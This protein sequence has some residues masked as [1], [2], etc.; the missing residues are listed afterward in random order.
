M[1]VV[2][3]GAG[4]PLGVRVCRLQHLEEVEAR[5]LDVLLHLRLG[6]VVCDDVGLVDDLVR[7]EL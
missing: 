7:D 2:V 4:W 3:W 5:Q 1:V 6:L